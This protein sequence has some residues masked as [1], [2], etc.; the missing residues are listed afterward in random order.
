VGAVVVWG[1]A[2]EAAEDREVGALE[3]D[4]V[5]VG[6]AGLRR[7]E[8]EPGGLG[9]QV[10]D[11]NRVEVDA[12]AP[13]DLEAVEAGAE[14]DVELDLRGA[15][16]LGRP[17]RPGLVGATGLEHVHLRGLSSARRGVVALGGVV[18]RRRAGARARDLALAH[19][20]VVDHLDLVS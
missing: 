19:P 3:A 18:D 2:G 5:P 6:P 14:V 10:S 13:E 9:W 16:A 17:A 7:V 8:V 12:R 15:A 20:A 4:V 1:P 11:A